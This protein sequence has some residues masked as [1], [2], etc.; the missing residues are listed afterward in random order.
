MVDGDG[1]GI[2]SIVIT[3]TYTRQTLN[4]VGRGYWVGNER[5]TSSELRTN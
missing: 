5:T 3:G 4:V 2:M 1:D